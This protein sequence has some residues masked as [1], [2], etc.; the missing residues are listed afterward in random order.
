MPKILFSNSILCFH[1]SLKRGFYYLLNE[2]SVFLEI[3]IISKPS[4]PQNP[5]IK[6]FFYQ[7][8]NVFDIQFVEDIF[9]MSVNGIFANE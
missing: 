7:P 6:G 2:D 4:L 1:S 5:Q 8:C 3:N 9:S